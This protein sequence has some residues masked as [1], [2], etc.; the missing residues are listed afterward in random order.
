MPV[1][2]TS[3]TESHSAFIYYQ[4]QICLNYICG[5]SHA[6][7]VLSG[8]ILV[9]RRPTSLAVSATIPVSTDAGRSFRAVNACSSIQTRIRQAFLC[10]FKQIAAW[11][12]V[13][14]VYLTTGVI[15]SQQVRANEHPAFVFRLNVAICRLNSEKHII[16]TLKTVWLYKLSTLHRNRFPSH[17]LLSCGFQ[18]FWILRWVN[19]L[20][21]PL[22]CHIVLY[23]PHFATLNLVSIECVLA[24]LQL[25]FASW[26][27]L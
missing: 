23:Q 4:L 5:P 26:I 17:F 7:T 14:T 27:Y 20:F 10:H 6:A 13:P 24:D 11:L 9:V 21:S 3:T 1:P 22:H 2:S 19:I 12:M 18:E 15:I 25:E 16:W 8:L